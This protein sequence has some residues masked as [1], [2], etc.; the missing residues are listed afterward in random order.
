VANV[1]I[2]GASGYTGAELMRLISAHPDLDL[3]AISSRQFSGQPAAQIFGAL[4]G[5]VSLSFVEPDHPSLIQDIDLVFLAVPHQAAMNAVPG[6]LEAGVKVVDLSADFRIKDASLYEKWYVPHTCP[7]YLAEAAYGLPE[8]NRELVKKARLTANPGCYVTS[9]IM[10]L[11][12]LLKDGLLKTSCIIADSA[13]GVSGAGRKASLNL[14]HGEVH[15]NFKP[16]SVAGHRHTPEME[17]ELSLAA[18]QEVR[19]TFTPH[20]LPM[21]RGIL[22]T[23]YAE[24]A[25]G[26]N[27]SDIYASWKKAFSGEPFVR[28]LAEGRLPATKE[29]R[30]TNRVQIGLAKDPR[31][32]LFKIFSA[33]DNI[34]KGASGQAL[35]N[36]NLMLGLDEGLGL[37]GLGQ[38][39]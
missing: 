29:V 8:F 13:S 37:A 28:V 18:G 22:S 36:A 5:E 20:L 33:L 14:I 34:T 30:G 38:T 32:G 35:Q 7:E 11:I 25:D 23:I 39:P 3:R 19:L 2:I 1:S 17:Q 24:P 4:E 26:T 10:P 15:E 16:Y 12:P 9:V 6:L 21:D 27:E 31:S